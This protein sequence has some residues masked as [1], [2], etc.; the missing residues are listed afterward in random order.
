MYTPGIEALSRLGCQTSGVEFLDAIS[1]A[2]HLPRFTRQELSI[3]GSVAAKVSVEVWARIGGFITSI[4]DLVALASISPQAM[5]A[6][7]N[8]VRYPWVKEFRLVDVIS[9]GPVPPIPETTESTDSEDIQHYFY[10]LG[11]A[12]FTA[13][14]DGRRINVELGQEFG[15]SRKT[16]SGR[17]KISFEVQTYLSGPVVITDNE[18]YILELD[19]DKAS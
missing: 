1:D 11:R 7:A 14:R 9:S 18:L 3:T 15:K 8:L 16:C 12:K 4:A 17:R 6:A 10:E 19:D 2:N 5:S 13:V